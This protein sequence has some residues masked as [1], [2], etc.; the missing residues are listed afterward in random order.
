MRHGVATE[1]L[2]FA[3]LLAAGLLGSVALFAFAL[4]LLVVVA[5]CLAATW[6]GAR[7]IVVGRS[8]DQA[9]V[10]EGRALTIRFQPHGLGGLP[11]HAE[12]R[13][14]NGAWQRLEASASRPCRIERPGAHLIGP[15]EVRVRDD[16]GLFSRHLTAGDPTVVL[17]L[18]APASVGVPSHPGGSDPR[19]DPEPDGLQPYARGTPVGRIHW[20]SVARAGEWQERRVITAPR[21][22]PLVVVDLSGAPSDQAIDWT[23]RAAAGQ[24]HGLARTG[25]CRVLLPGERVPIPVENLAEGWPGVHRRLANLRSAVVLAA[26]AA[27]PGAL[28]IRADRAPA[29]AAAQPRPL[30]LDVV[31]LEQ[32]TFG[33]VAGHHS[34]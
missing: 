14:E 17:V 1:V 3:L 18:P 21:V 8:V 28:H 20:P 34:S 9:E 7:R 2:G 10:V 27:P 31:P 32:S 4:G 15:S 33:H 29:F 5:G 26:P 25:G 11:V 6:L 16:L 13:D 24:I 19:G 22:M 12:V 30:P 23:L